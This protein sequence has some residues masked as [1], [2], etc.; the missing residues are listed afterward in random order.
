MKIK[1]IIRE[2]FPTESPGS[3]DKSVLRLYLKADKE[4][5]D[6]VARAVRKALEGGG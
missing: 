1:L 5:V 3:W 6:R 2:V 4:V